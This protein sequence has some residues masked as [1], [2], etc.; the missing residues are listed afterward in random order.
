[1]NVVS[2]KYL[3]WESLGGQGGEHPLGSNR[4]VNLHTG[5]RIP[6]EAA[7]F[8]FDLFCFFWGGDRFLCVTALSVLELAL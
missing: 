8:C 3:G 6:I 5:C 1:M 2:R 4:R 7:A